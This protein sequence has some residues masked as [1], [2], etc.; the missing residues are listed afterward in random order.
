MPDAL[1]NDETKYD[2]G[3]IVTIASMASFVSAPGLVDYCVSKIGALYLTEGIRAECLARY[4]GGE[5]ICTTSIH[6]SWHQTGILN[7]VSMDLLEKHG[8]VPDPPSRVSNVVLE[9]VLKGR[10][11][12]ICVP[13][14][15]ELHTGI[16]NWPR[17]AQD[18]AFGL[19]RKR[20]EGEFEKDG[21]LT[22]AALKRV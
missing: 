16:R 18:V 14:S 15:Q 1:P 12:R 17:W 5:G 20:K 7:N 2:Q 6:P 9:Q 21:S 22:A 19:V 3:H 4:P 8:I 13:K 10:S 11:G